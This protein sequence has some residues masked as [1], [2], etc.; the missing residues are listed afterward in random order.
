MPN[1]QITL[2]TASSGEQPQ[3]QPEQNEHRSWFGPAPLSNQRNSFVTGAFGALVVLGLYTILSL[4]G[5]VVAALLSYIAGAILFASLLAT[6]FFIVQGL[7]KMRSS[8]RKQYAIWDLYTAVAIITVLG[9]FGAACVQTFQPGGAPLVLWTY[10]GT[11]A[12]CF[13]ACY[14]L[15]KFVADLWKAGDKNSK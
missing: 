12:A 9:Y 1:N 7:K 5:S 3:D 11:A 4:L 8:M 2:S 13:A 10:A 14:G 6:F 15:G